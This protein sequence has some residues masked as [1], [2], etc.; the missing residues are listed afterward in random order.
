MNIC[1]PNIAPKKFPN[2]E[3]DV[4]QTENDQFAVLGG[5][6]FWCV[7]GVYLQLQGV[8]DVTSG[9]SGGTISSAN[10]EAVCTGQ[11][12]H[13]EV[14]RIKFDSRQI[15]YGEILKIFFSIAHDPTQLNM[16]GNDVGKQYRSVV[17]YKG[18]QQ[19]NVAKKYID[20]LNNIK[21]Y[22]HNI[23]TAIEPLNEF[24]EAESYHQRYVENNLH[25]PYILHT[26]VPKIEKIKNQFPE[27]IKLQN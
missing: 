3:E 13:A 20:Q 17:F 11:T 7:E 19:K 1:Y 25:N 8:L 4:T 26:A 15:T 6:C 22:D 2:P 5:G 21:I 12:D 18:D 9:Y 14:I 10:Y 23:V 24:F 27:K 16:Q